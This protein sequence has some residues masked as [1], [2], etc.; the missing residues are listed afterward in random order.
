MSTQY[1]DDLLYTKDHEWARIEQRGDTRIA[2]I[3][4]TR[5]AVEQLGDV[6]QIE[7]PKEGESVKQAEIFGSVESVKAVSDLFAPLSGK[8]VKVNSPLGDSPEY[9]NEDPYD[10]GW[11]IQIALAN[12]D[13]LK[14][15]MDADTY[16]TFVKEQA[17]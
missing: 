1:P 9:V 3:G 4:I 2:T 7:L 11:M 12:A 5:F 17:E 8:V 14:G 15:L 10:E 6:T 13:E 16:Q